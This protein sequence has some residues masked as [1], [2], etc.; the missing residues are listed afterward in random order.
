MLSK[1]RSLVLLAR[2]AELE[3]VHERSGG[4]AWL[5]LHRRFLLDFLV[6]FDV[7]GDATASVPALAEAASRGELPFVIVEVREVS[8]FLF[9]KRLDAGAD[10]LVLVVRTI[11]L[12]EISEYFLALGAALNRSFGVVLDGKII[13]LDLEL[14]LTQVLVDT[15]FGRS[16]DAA[17][18]GL[19]V[20]EVLHV[21]C[22]HV[23]QEEQGQCTNREDKCNGN[24][25][26]QPC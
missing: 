7:I 11:L 5:L 19:A 8:R 1:H 14:C 12:G 15:L 10:L 9:N 21:D 18:R 16:L 4:W 26:G 6:F 13:D 25:V 3:A 2:L 23:S 22:E 20:Q 17:A 24:A